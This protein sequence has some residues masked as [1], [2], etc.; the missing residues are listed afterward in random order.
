VVVVVVVIVVVDRL[1]ASTVPLRPLED[2]SGERGGE[3]EYF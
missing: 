1:P 2:E 3:G